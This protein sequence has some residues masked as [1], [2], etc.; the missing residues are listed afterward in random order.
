MHK[1]ELTGPEHATVL[2]ALRMWQ[3]NLVAEEIPPDYI[4]IS[5]DGDKYGEMSCDAVDDLCEKINAVPKAEELIV[6]KEGEYLITYNVTEEVT[7]SRVIKVDGACLVEEDSLRDLVEE[8][9]VENGDPIKDMMSVDER[10][11]DGV[12]VTDRD[13]KCFSAKVFFESRL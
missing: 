4:E 5:T 13:G 10:D 8:D 6:L 1:I 12:W 7:Y 2:A 3:E 9:W 11:Y